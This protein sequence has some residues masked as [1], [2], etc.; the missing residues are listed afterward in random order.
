MQ[1]LKV[2]KLYPNEMSTNQRLADPLITDTGSDLNVYLD[3]SAGG[4]C[5]ATK[6]MVSD[7]NGEDLNKWF[8]KSN[9]QKSLQNAAHNKIKGSFTIY[10][11][12]N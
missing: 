3:D 4:C 5:S 7:L 10:G 12:K 2:T 1:A 6:T 9:S 11:I 8:G